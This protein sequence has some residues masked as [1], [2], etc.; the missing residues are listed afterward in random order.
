MRSTKHS[1]NKCNSGACKICG[2]KHNSLLHLSSKSEQN[3]RDQSEGSEKSKQ[4]N[5][6]VQTST[7]KLTVMTHSSTSYN[8][9]YN[10][11]TLLLT[12]VVY[13]IDGNGIKQTCCVLLDS[14][15]QANFITQSYANRLRLDSCPSNIRI[16][17]INGMMSNATIIN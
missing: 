2:I 17:G 15:S 5:L 3:S 16:T 11:C 8:S 10:S 12:A 4:G 9:S 7:E 13:I 6:P 1:A 14:D